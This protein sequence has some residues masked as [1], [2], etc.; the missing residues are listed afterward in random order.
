MDTSSRR[1]FALDSRTVWV[2]QQIVG[3]VVLPRDN[4]V[5]GPG[6]YNARIIERHISTPSIGG[7]RR[8]IDNFPTFR[9]DLQART[10]LGKGSPSRS[11]SP[12]KREAPGSKLELR[13]FA[14]IHLDNDKRQPFDPKNGFCPTPSGYIGH[15]PA[16]R[17]IKTDGV[18]ET[19]ST[20]PF[21]GNTIPVPFGERCPTKPALPD[22]DPQF[23]SAQLR[24]ATKQ[25]SFEK[26][27]RIYIPTEEDTRN[28]RA[29]K[30]SPGTFSQELS[31]LRRTN[32][33]SPT[34]M[35]VFQMRCG[36][37]PMPKLKYRSPPV[38]LFD[39]SSYKNDL[40][41][42]PLDLHPKLVNQKA[43]V[44]LYNKIVAIPRKHY[45]TGV[46]ATKL[47]V[48]PRT[49]AAAGED[50]ESDSAY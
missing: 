22:Y 46:A 32:P 6:E 16:L 5:L 1:A 14:S 49:K 38:L 40:T 29:S 3:P 39:D 18:Y 30:D 15:T 44:Q 11:Q 47:T 13:D 17:I 10:P 34:R 36:L 50:D 31:P 19:K 24:P 9:S 28:H 48:Q 26:S 43:Q 4:L 27:K 23:D 7:S 42:K 41:S 8:S 20:L 45:S 35:S 33:D 37:V 21:G 12:P 25:G 2:E